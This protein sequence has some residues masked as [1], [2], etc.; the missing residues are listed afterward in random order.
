MGTLRRT[1][2]PL[3]TTAAP[4]EPA[5]DG[6]HSSAQGLVQPHPSG[7]TKRPTRHPK[8]HMDELT[9]KQAEEGAIAA[10]QVAE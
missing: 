3:L 6:D 10:D 1:W 5:A 4:S 9:R 2:Q 8:L 7:S